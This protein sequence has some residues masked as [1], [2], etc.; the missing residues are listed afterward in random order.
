MDKLFIKE[1]HTNDTEGYRMGDSDWYETFTSDKGRLF[2]DLQKEYGAA[3]KMYIDQKDGSAKQVGW[4]FRKTRKYEDCD[5]TY[6]HS[7]W[8][9]VSETKPY[10]DCTLKNVKHPF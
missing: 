2:R 6:V 1:S 8:V 4:V 9:E 10:K 7:V 3:T 5:K